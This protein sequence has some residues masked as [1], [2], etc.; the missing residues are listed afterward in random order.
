VTA[1]SPSNRLSGLQREF[2]RRISSH[3]SAFFLTGAVLAGWVLGHRRTDDLDLFT[4]DDTAMADADRLMRVVAAE[5][6]TSLE[7]VQTAPDFRRYLL[8]S[9]PTLW[10]S[11]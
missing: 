6:G 10:S 9:G 5:L 2:L 7:S 3:T 4:T 11:T 1:S 8:R